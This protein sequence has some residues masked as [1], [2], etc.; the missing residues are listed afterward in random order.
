MQLM[1]QTGSNT[2]PASA[3]EIAAVPTV[4]ISADQLGWYG[5]EFVASL[6]HYLPV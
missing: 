2:P 1:R 5:L 3:S 6:C 4:N